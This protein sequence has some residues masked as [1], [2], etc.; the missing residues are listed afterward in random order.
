MGLWKRI[1][2]FAEPPAGRGTC[3]EVDGVR[4]AVFR[5]NGALCALAGTC[6][7][8]GGPLG[9]G[10]LEGQVVACPWHG[11][12][13]DVTT[14]ANVHAPEISVRRYPLETRP[15]GVWAELE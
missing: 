4:L 15:D 14:G 3:V 11:W 12:E 10:M 13:F 6:P 1:D 2:E 5:V 7:H 8:R 9:E